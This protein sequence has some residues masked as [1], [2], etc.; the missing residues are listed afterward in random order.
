MFWIIFLSAY[1]VLNI[2]ACF[3]FG[4]FLDEGWFRTVL[5]VPDVFSIIE[6][7]NA[8]KW[9]AITATSIF[10]I[11]FAPAIILWYMAVAIYLLVILIWN[12][13]RPIF[14]KN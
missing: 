5:V 13:I 7:F 14:F 10:T 8:R 2:T 1:A 12:G 6:E 3:A 11:F 9:F 4:A